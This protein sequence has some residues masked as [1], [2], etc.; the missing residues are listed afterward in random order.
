MRRIHGTDD[1]QKEIIQALRDVGASVFVTSGVGG[2]FPDIVVALRGVNYLMEIKDGE[3]YPSQRKLNATEQDFH[4]RWQG[5]CAVVESV[6]EA[7]EM[8]GLT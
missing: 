8:I 4:D 3:K 7:F 6:D 1:N 5:P 2:G